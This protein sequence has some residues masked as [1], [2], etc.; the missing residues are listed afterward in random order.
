MPSNVTVH[1]PGELR[2]QV[3]DQNEVQIGGASVK[4]VLGSLRDVTT[5]QYPQPHHSPRHAKSVTT[6]D[7]ASPKKK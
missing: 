1:I 7:Q 2:A 5:T 3:D 6:R 4:E